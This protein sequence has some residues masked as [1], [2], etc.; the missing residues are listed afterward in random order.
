MSPTR[1]I[2][3]SRFGAIEVASDIVL[4]F[5]QV[6][7]F[8]AV[9]LGFVQQQLRKA[10]PGSL[11]PGGEHRLTPDIQRAAAAGARGAA[12]VVGGGAVAGQRGCG[13]DVGIA[14]VEAVVLAEEVLPDFDD[15]TVAQAI[16]RQRIDTRIQSE[17][18]DHPG[19]SLEYQVV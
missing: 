6:G 4:D 12:R 13:A 1:K 15:G 2:E 11:D 18:T 7:V 19:E 8:G 3:S 16:G 9:R 14:D 17:V 5:P 10:G